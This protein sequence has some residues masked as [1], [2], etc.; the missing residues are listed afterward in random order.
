MPREEMERIKTRVTWSTLIYVKMV[1][2]WVWIPVL[3]C[4]QFLVPMPIRVFEFEN[5]LLD[6]RKQQLSEGEKWFFKLPNPKNRY[7]FLLPKY[8]GFPVWCKYSFLASFGQTF[9]NWSFL[10]DFGRILHFKN[11]RTL[12]RAPSNFS[13]N[14][15]NDCFRLLL[16]SSCGC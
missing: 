13:L 14:F 9:E 10:A 6:I 3:M 2:G 1:Y 7:H 11:I 8:S 5:S 12:W 15:I 16:H 4:R